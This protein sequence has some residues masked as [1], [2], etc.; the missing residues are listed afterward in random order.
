MMGANK[1]RLRIPGLMLAKLTA[2]G[3]YA[4]KQQMIGAT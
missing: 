4:T 1:D 3:A 2:I